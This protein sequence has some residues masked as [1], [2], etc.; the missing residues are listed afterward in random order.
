LDS[1]LLLPG[2]IP[3]PTPGIPYL[4]SGRLSKPTTGGQFG[5]TKAS[6]KRLDIALK[7]LKISERPIPTKRVCDMYDTVRREILT[8]FALQKIMWKKEAEVISRRKK[9]VSII[10]ESAAEKVTCVSLSENKDLTTSG[11][12]ESRTVLLHSEKP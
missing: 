3:T 11:T 9:L 5:P 12:T 10:G 1:S 2:T 7:E 4:Q 6:L 8:L